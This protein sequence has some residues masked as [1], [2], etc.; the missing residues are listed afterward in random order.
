VTTIGELEEALV[1]IAAQPDRA[2]YIEVMIPAEESVSLPDNVIDHIYKL[3]TP[4][5]A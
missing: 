4:T 1:E 5:G 2:A 3:K